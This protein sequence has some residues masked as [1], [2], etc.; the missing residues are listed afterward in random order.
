MEDPAQQSDVTPC[1][2]DLVRDWVHE[3]LEFRDFIV[4]KRTDGHFITFGTYIYG[5][6]EG[7]KVVFGSLVGDQDSR[8]NVIY[9]WPRVICAADP[10]FF[11]MLAGEFVD[12][13][14]SG[15]LRPAW[16]PY[17]GAWF[18]PGASTTGGC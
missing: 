1:L 7:D 13:Q 2:A 9:R 8:A 15:K 14:K 10:G 12:I 4:I 11:D 6:F 3:H 17:S 18:W 5:Y 16:D